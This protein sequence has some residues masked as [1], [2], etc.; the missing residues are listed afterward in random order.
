MIELGKKQTLQIVRKTEHGVYMGEAG[1]EKNAVLLPT[2]YV[3][4]EMAVGSEQE[5]FIYRDSED[6]LIATTRLPKIALGEMAGLTV[7]DV[8][9]F[10]AFLDW[11]LEK[12]LFLPFKEQTHRV[13]P[14]EEVLAALYI[15]KSGRLCATMKVS[16]FLSHESP[17]KKDDKVNGIIYDLKKEF[18]AFVAVD[19]RYF[20]LI[21]SQE[22]YQEGKVGDWIEARVLRVREDGKLDLSGRKKAYKQIE[23]DAKMV[24]E[25]IRELGGRL[26][27]NDRA[28][29]ERIQRELGLS[30]NAFK[31]AVGHLLKEGRIEIGEDFIRAREESCR[32]S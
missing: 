26:P 22:W 5:V 27:F 2:R 3:T 1:D 21:P 8:T 29:P 11:G 32:I 25:R 12:D 23:A 14:K 18:G 19:G 4:P 31:R 28:E 9:K 6:R 10:G 16:R 20:G 17:Y 13:Q 15:D 7:K 30:K 24:A